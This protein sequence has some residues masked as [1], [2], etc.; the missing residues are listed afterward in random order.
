MTYDAIVIGVGGMG[1]AAVFHLAAA[2]AKVLGLEQFTI[3]HVYGSSHGSTRIIRLAYSEGDEYVPLLRS[4]YQYWEELE[5]ISGKRLL[6]KTGG[7]DIG[8]PDSWTIQG[9]RQSCL[10]HAIPFEELAG[11][12]VNRRFP[13]YR[14]PASLGAIFQRDGGYLLSELAVKTYAE[15][16]RAQGAEIHE[17][18]KVLRWESDGR[19]V[20]VETDAGE[21]RA[22]RLVLT[23]GPWTGLVGAKLRP[24]C[25]PERQVLLWTEP[26][27]PNLYER[28]AFP[29]FN[30]E[31]PEG[32][33]YGF[34]NHEGEGFKI[35]RYHHLEQ[36]V[37]DPADI[38][39][40]CGP[41][42][43]A[44]LRLGIENYFP[45]ANGATRKMTTCIF[46][47]SPDEDFFLDRYPGEEQV[48]VAAGFS[49]HGFKFCSVVG[50]IMADFCLERAPAWD[51]TRFSVSRS[52]R[53]SA[54]LSRT[55]SY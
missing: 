55:P 5:Q 4:A 2:G 27:E 25:Q 21:Y 24:L 14:L 20:K 31:S 39:R 40:V 41:G 52:P 35:G 45:A 49:G 28:S 43:E 11:A 29:V 26:L 12:E 1:S 13:G 32:R 51:L 42:D 34:P 23:A 53:A 30:M 48:F 33:Y 3:P 9:S 8:P 10:T 38:D 15:A 47:N 36:R 16:A 50:R 44:V 19:G 17:Q 46:T 18:E 22:M 7:L 54:G 37:D 6:F